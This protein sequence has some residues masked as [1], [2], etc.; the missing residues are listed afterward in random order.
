MR[1][2][3]KRIVIEPYVVLDNTDIEEQSDKDHRG[4]EREERGLELI[5]E[6]GGETESTTDEGE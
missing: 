1:I 5:I 6:I 2:F 4:A 3:K